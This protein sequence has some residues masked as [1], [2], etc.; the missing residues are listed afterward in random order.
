MP[1]ISQ[2]ILSSWSFDPRVVLGLAVALFLYTRG[3]VILYRTLPQRFPPWR[4][5][6]FTGGLATLWLAISS[7]LD[8]FSGLLLSA[9]MVQH[10]LLMSVAPPLILLGA[11]FLPLLRGLPRKFARDGLGPFLTWPALRQ[12]GKALTHP[13]N[14]W[15]FMTVTLCAWHVPALFDLALRSPA[16]HKVE[17]ACFFTA[18]LFFW[19]PVVRPFPSRPQ[20]PLWTVPFYL[21]AADLLNTA[22]SA[23]LT[24]SERVLYPTYL[25]APRLFGTTV[26]GDQSAAGVIMWV[27]GSLVFLVPA[28]LIAVQYLS[29]GNRLVRPQRLHSARDSRSA[30]LIAGSSVLAQI[31]QGVRVSGRSHSLTPSFD[32]LRVPILG[33]FLRARSGRLLMQGTL[34]IA[35]IAVISDGLFGPQVSS[36]NLAGVLPWT[37]WRPLIV[38]ALLA[39]GNFFCLACP[40]TLFRKLGRRLGLRQRSWPRALRSKWFSIGLLVL[41]FWAYEVFS[42]WDRPMWTAWLIIN[43]F[44]LALAI[45]AL[46]TGASFC[47][48]VCP[49]GQFQFI[50]SLVSPLEVK[51]REPAVCAD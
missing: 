48:Y 1:S 28:A 32:L 40:F 18:W 31:F 20:W 3:W 4:L 5:L 14:C 19:F 7:P 23:I 21:L 36:A 42:L 26:L 8:A 10:L 33:P 37:Y 39:A 35:A 50:A 34:F 15:I 9:H 12:V 43:Y 47:K 6:A 25:A 22:L 13:M 29:S 30:P 24:F 2:A 11:P 17:H 49:I 45:D 38:I 41:F 46:F 44:L 16:W 27:P 51:V